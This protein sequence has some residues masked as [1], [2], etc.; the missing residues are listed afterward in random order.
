VE[1]LDHV[2][3][4]RPQRDRDQRVLTRERAEAL[5]ESLREVQDRRSVSRDEVRVVVHPRQVG[6]GTH[7]RPSSR[8]SSARDSSIR[9]LFNAIPSRYISTVYAQR[10]IRSRMARDTRSET[11]A[12]LNVTV[13]VDGVVML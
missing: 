8:A 5:D 13:T 6:S 9:L 1:V 12:S 7:C 3:V 2:G 4:R 10:A 11:E